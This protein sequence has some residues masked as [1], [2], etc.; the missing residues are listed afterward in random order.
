M[1]S[2]NS[3]N[4][5]LARLLHQHRAEKGPRET[6]SLIALLGNNSDEH[7]ACS[8][9]KLEKLLLVGQ[10][11]STTLKTLGLDKLST[12]DFV[13]VKPLLMTR[14]SAERRSDEVGQRAWELFRKGTAVQSIRDQLKREEL[15]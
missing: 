15:I 5:E 12:D 8:T 9:S 10:F 14:K 2:L 4:W 1:L 6:A 3:R 7:G 11:S 13:D